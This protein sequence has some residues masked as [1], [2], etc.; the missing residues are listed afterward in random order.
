MTS[1]LHPQLSHSTLVPREHV[2]RD[3][4]SEVY[5]TDIICDRYPNFRIGV[6]LPKSHSYYS[7]H[8]G[9]AEHRYDP[10]L[11]LE[12]FRQ[13]SILIAHRHVD[14]DFG[15][16][17]IF[18]SADIRV[19]S[20][21][22]MTITAKPGNGEVSAVIVGEKVRG[23]EVIGITLEMECLLGG[24]AAAAVT[25]R[26]Q[27]MPRGIWT[28]VRNKGRARL[29]LGEYRTGIEPQSGRGPRTARVVH[30]A[31]T[32]GRR[33]IRNAVLGDAT[34]TAGGFEIDVLVD[35][36]HPSLFDHPLDHIPGAVLFE[37]IRQAG[38]FAAHEFHGL[39]ARRLVLTSLRAEFTR[40]G[41]LDLHTVI[42]IR[43][44]DGPDSGFT[45]EVEVLQ[46]EEPITTGCVRLIRHVSDDARGVLVGG[47]R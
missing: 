35:Q 40:F 27:W 2:H 5:L 33:I 44:V 4:L 21:E 36:R 30:P 41:E 29:G 19:I 28:R 38:I 10:L 16:A 39:S 42:R 11:V 45:F 46:E 18:N 31:E 32:L 23:D 43:P 12:C 6:H 37:A 26:I 22:A 24:V 3:A 7:D 1:T 20:P 47:A 14:V 13:T 17:F 25:M 15:Q 34:T 9:P 8:I